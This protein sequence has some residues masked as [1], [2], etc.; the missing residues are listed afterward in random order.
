MP[1]PM[2]NPDGN[3]GKRPTLSEKTQRSTDL[4]RGKVPFTGKTA[5]KRGH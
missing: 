1:G 2:S 4:Q 5:K 3:K